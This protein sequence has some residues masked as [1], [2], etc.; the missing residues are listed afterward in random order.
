MGTWWVRLITV[1]IF[2]RLQY[3]Q[4]G[5]AVRKTTTESEF[6]EIVEG[7]KKVEQ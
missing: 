3:L 7:G 2:P 1:I 4:T 5:T 6:V